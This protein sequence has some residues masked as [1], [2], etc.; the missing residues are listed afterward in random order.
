M[1][2]AVVRLLSDNYRVAAR[3]RCCLAAGLRESDNVSLPVFE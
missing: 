1:R 2:D 3:K